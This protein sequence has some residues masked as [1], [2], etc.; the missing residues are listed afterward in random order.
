MVRDNAGSGVA[1][2]WLSAWLQEP[3]RVPGLGG[4][5]IVGAGEA[6]RSVYVEW[7]MAVVGRGCRFGEGTKAG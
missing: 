7:K 4:L 2:T 1:R 3:W 5:M 6:L